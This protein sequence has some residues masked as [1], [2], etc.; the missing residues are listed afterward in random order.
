MAKQ[1]FHI[2]V[3][4]LNSLLGMNVA[5]AIVI[6]NIYPLMYL[7]QLK[8]ICFTEIKM[9]V[10]KHEHVYCNII[11]LFEVSSTHSQTP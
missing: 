6:K 2:S 3:G 8:V 10:Q 9:S 7:F 11:V 5:I 4:S 1:A